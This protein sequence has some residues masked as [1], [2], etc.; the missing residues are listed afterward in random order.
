MEYEDFELQI[1]PRLGDE[2]RLHVLR[3][4]AGEGEASSRLSGIVAGSGCS[5]PPAEVGSRLF[6]ALFTG[7][8]G[9][10]FHQSLSRVRGDT[11][12]R[13]LRIRLRINPRDPS[14]AAL[15]RVSWELLHREE[16][17][18]FLALSRLTPIVRSLDIP[19]ASRPR[20][21]EP[22]LRILVVLSQDPE[23][24]DLH[25]ADEAKQLGEI[26][27]RQRGIEIEYLE[28]PDTRTLRRSLVQKPFHVL[29][30]MGHSGFDPG[31]GEGALLFHGPQGARRVI[32]GRHL[33]TKIKDFGSLRLVVLNACETALA[34]AEAGQS[35]F[36]GVATALVLG[37]VPAVVAMQ[38]PIPNSHALA[39]S[40][41]FYERL[42]EGLPV[43]EAV[44]EGRQA[45]HSL[46]PESADWA[47]PVLFLRTSSGDLF[48]TTKAA[49]A[50]AS[51][52]RMPVVGR[53]MRAGA[54]VAL[55]LLL[56]GSIVIF[57]R[58]GEQAGRTDGPRVSTA[59]RPPA[60]QP[61]VLQ[62]SATQPSASQLSTSQPPAPRPSPSPVTASRT[63]APARSVTI[64]SLRFEIAG[65][66]AIR[67]ALDSALRHIAVP[68]APSTLSGR[69]VRLE[70]GAPQLAHHTEE[71]LPWSSC[72]VTTMCRIY[73]HGTSVDLGTASG[74]R[75]QVDGAAAC[76]AAVSAL[77]D[78]VHQRITRY[79][80]EKA[81]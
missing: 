40:A 25:L 36:S 48:A 79:L 15:Q 51:P 4:P 8:V 66:R 18:D 49:E 22:P 12:V 77:A 6:R 75:S 58:S 67:T 33:A 45:I 73:D 50:Q 76:D 72:R 56:L 21:L 23:K 24:G 16:T 78:D 10:L 74:V 44:T 68:F 71:G 34:G 39:F 11:P 59:P 52:D 7:Q 29:H 27:A 19:R 20:P 47:V 32:S 43:D 28:T 64:G 53:R 65:N 54:Q 3:S 2:F 60:S 17:E 5:S 9:E 70:V 46:K 69:T 63:E 31:S 35:P 57:E 80:K 38:S 61:S 13:G 14:L 41:A 1:G 30:Y 26:L 42:A 81:T 62:P 55:S 37:G